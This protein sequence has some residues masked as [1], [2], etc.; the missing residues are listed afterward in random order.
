MPAPT[1]RV[2]A[3]RTPARQLVATVL[4][5]LTL[6][7]CAGGGTQTSCDLG[8]CTVTFPRSGNGATAA[9]VSVLGV[10]ARLVGVSGGAATIE[11]AGQRLTLPAGGQGTA[12]G[13]TVG[14]Q[15]V[16]DTEVVVVVRPDLGG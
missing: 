4:L 13:F 15:S 11:V 14:V 10:T 2:A 6:A 5:A 16:T 8:G 7:G 3:R 12:E 9:E 1:R